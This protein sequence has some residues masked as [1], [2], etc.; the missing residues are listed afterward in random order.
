MPSRGIPFA[1]TAM[2]MKKTLK[3]QAKNAPIVSG[4]VKSTEMPA[5]TTDAALFE[6]LDG[7]F[8]NVIHNGRNHMG[9]IK[10]F[11][12]LIQDDNEEGE[13]T[14]RWADKIV[15]SVEQMEKY[16]G[17]LAMFRINDALSVTS[18]SW[19]ELIEQVLDRCSYS[20]KRGLSIDVVR[21]DKGTIRQRDELLKRVLVHLVANAYESVA[22]D[23]TISLT[24]SD[25]PDENQKDHTTKAVVRVS[26][27]GCGIEDKYTD[28]IWKP[29]FTTKLDHV[30]LGL[31]FVS[32]AAPILGADVKLR[33]KTGE[34]T[35]VKLVLNELGG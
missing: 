25:S 6:D 16:L 11:A 19:S 9:P 26:D 12:S 15:R 31:T 3:N 27:T 33:S 8:S 21:E 24:V 29:F 13:N 30:G 35:T 1:V 2:T 28:S 34:G 17:L 10:G 32:V 7:M 18:V 20:N 4:E 14:R 5:P 22:G 23:G